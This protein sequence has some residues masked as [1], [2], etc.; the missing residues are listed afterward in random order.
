MRHTDELK[1]SLRWPNLIGEG[2]DVERIAYYRFAI[3][4]KFLLGATANERSDRVSIRY[5]ARYQ[6]SP[7]V[8]GSSGDE[9]IAARHTAL[10]RV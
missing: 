5:Q 1:E 10:L 4:R 3:R 8:A 9:D 2:F 7:N 6:H